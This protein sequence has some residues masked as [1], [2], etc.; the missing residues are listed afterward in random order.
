M[1]RLTLDESE[2]ERGLRKS[3]T[4]AGEEVGE[5]GK[6]D[7]KHFSDLPESSGLPHSRP[8]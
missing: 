2:R 4:T 1:P 7:R 8:R 5:G 3:E 6:R